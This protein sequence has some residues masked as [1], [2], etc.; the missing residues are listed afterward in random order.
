MLLSTSSQC[1]NLI[2]C[3]WDVGHM[4][5]INNEAKY[6]RGTIAYFSADNLGAQYIGGYKQGSQ[7]HRKCQE[8]M[9]INAEIQSQVENI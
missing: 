4:F 3:I 5:L 2:Y 9:V 8:C 1:L 6:F 7:S